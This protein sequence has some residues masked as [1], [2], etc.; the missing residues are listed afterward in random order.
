MPGAVRTLKI[1]LPIAFIA[2]VAII[3]VSFSASKAQKRAET[4]VP[5]DLRRPEQ[6]QRI[7]DQF[8]GIQTL[9]GRT[10]LR[11][12]ADR[13]VGFE[14]GWY[15]L[16]GVHLTVYRA[17][18]QPYDVQ[19][20]QA[21]I[22]A[23]TKELEATDGVVLRSAD[24]VE[25]RTDRLQFKSGT[26]I[27]DR[28][29]QFAMS[30]WRGAAGGVRMNVADESVLLTGGV[31]GATPAT[32]EG[33]ATSFRADESE[34][35]RKAGELK[36][37]GNV[38]LLRGDDRFVSD[39][40]SLRADEKTDRLRSFIG[41]GSARV[42][43]RR[44]PGA[45][46]GDVG[47][48]TIDAQRF[49]GE[50]D[51]L[52]V[53]AA[54][55]A[56][57]SPAHATLAGPPTRVITAPRFRLLAP[58]GNLAEVQATGGVRMV[59]TQGPVRR[60]VDAFNVN[61][62]FNPDGRATALNAQ[63]GVRFT[64]GSMIGE[65]DRAIWDLPGDRM[66]LTSDPPRLPALRTDSQNFRARRIDVEMRQGVLTANEQV[67]AALT[68]RSG[69]RNAVFSANGPIYVNAE[70][71]V[72][73]RDAN[74]AVFQGNV[75]AWQGDDTLL[76]S[77]MRI[78]QASG[79]VIASGD[80]RTRLSPREGAGRTA[81]ASPIRTAS[82]LLTARR[83]ENQIILEESVTVEEQ[84]RT[85]TADKAIV[86]LNPDGGLRNVEASG[87]LALK[88]KATGRSGAGDSAVYDPGKGTIIVD[89]DPASI[90]D[91]RG[92]VRGKQILFDVPRNRVQVLSGSKPT[93]ATYNPPS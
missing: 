48:I 91:P 16:E 40:A 7:G 78:D 92:E 38:E 46:A 39:T 10:V 68:P 8:E 5:R 52:G 55:Q 88:E 43:M 34:Y 83:N 15:T 89:G 12:R 23:D 3:A 82:K 36:L 62:L 67:Y 61:A 70:K 9:G 47:A 6:P 59:E 30:S 57:G 79:T 51:E 24:G 31:T 80:V 77:E 76:A 18:G 50:F 69:A 63:G 37:R 11:I 4:E 22:H 44:V 85:V 49:E 56:T 81:A 54:I 66:V 74:T 75:R 21:Q 29:L 26:L 33:P 27:G 53:I 14:S 42:S 84:G 41:E 93:E 32:P 72:L 35:L 13:T 58:G 2:F 28:P 71:G 65:S 73:R 1:V 86:N 19:A 90:T 17:G 45:S 64:D 60:Q 20:A 87:N 25:V